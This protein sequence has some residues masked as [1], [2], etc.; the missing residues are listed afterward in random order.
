MTFDRR[1]PGMSM[2][3][4]VGPINPMRPSLILLACVG[5]FLP[6]V[7]AKAFVPLMAGQQARPL[8]GQF[9]SVPVLH[10]NQPE[11]V[12]GPGILINTAPGQAVSQDTGQVVANP[13][14]TFNGE[15]GAHLHHKYL[16]SDRSRLSSRREL[17]LAAILINPGA[18][19]VQ[20]QFEAGAVRNS[21]EA[22]Y[23]PNHLMGVKAL[24]PR[25]WNTGPGDATA[26]QMLRGKLDARLPD[27]ITIPPYGRLVL[28]R[29]EIPS[30]GIANALLRGRSDGPFQ[31]AVVAAEDPRSDE[32][33]LAVL[34]RGLLAPGRVYLRR[35]A[36]IQNRKVFSRVG[37]VAIGDTYTASIN[38]DLDA[39]P[40]HV[41]LT[42]T[43]RHHFG[44]GDVQV[45]GLASRTIDSSIDNVGTYGVRFNLTLNLRGQGPYSLVLSHPTP[46][47]R[48]FTAFRGSIGI[49]TEQGYKEVHVGMRSGE[50]LEL[51]P[52]NLQPDRTN[53]VRLSLVY[54]ADATPG[55]LLSV[56]PQSQ[57]AQL[58]QREQLLAQAR[59]AEEARRRALSSK[60]PAVMAPPNPL[61]PTLARRDGSGD[62]GNPDPPRQQPPW[63]PPLATPPPVLINRSMLSSPVIGARGYSPAVIPPG[64]IGQSLLEGYQRAV[65]AQQRLLNSLINR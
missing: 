34:D 63:L 5:V 27:S 21:F 38:H 41:P 3:R 33:V 43:V 57:L 48:T 39:T 2:V 15:F 19:P 50:S 17:D 24:G 37:G 12:Y 10:S 11:E 13:V 56:V 25:P 45:N 18:Q 26:I 31:M 59:Q 53:T 62:P 58:Q 42:S 20:I 22:P 32:D 30:L 6:L 4:P 9:N 8:N 40:L 54:P 60:P 47:G 46:N 65:E 49:E 55:H 7:G 52:L 23:L 44:T 61:G 14:F 35:L 1:S 64:R 29:T 51:K 16:P 28:F 36:E